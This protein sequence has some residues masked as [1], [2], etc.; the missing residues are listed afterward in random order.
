MRATNGATFEVQWLPFQLNPNASKTGVNR[1]EY[2]MKKFG[3]SKEGTMSMMKGFKGNFDRAGLP[4]TFTEHGL[5]GNTINGH[6][7]VSYARHVGGAAM[8]DVVM[9]ELFKNFFADEAFVNDPKVLLAAA[10]KGGIPEADA[11]KLV[12]DDNMFLKETLAEMSIGKQLRVSGVPHFVISKEGKQGGLQ[13]SGAQPAEDFADAFQDV[14][15][16]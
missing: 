11:Q 15:Q 14:L 2:Y 16:T 9:E 13:M 1:L 8:Q 6:R 3:R 4:F 7:I 10:L 12:A 5:T